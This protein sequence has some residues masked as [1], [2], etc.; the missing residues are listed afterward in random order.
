LGGAL[1]GDGVIRS[2]GR[3]FADLFA[4]GDYAAQAAGVLAGGDRRDVQMI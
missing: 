4:R 2:D 3:I 1:S